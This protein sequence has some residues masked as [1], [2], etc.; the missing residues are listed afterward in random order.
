M[1][2][3]YLAWPPGH[4]VEMGRPRRQNRRTASLVYQVPALVA[5][6]H[7]SICAFRCIFL[8]PGARRGIGGNFLALGEG[9]G[10]TW[11]KGILSHTGSRRCC[12]QQFPLWERLMDMIDK[13]RTSI[14]KI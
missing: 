4:C 10:R 11:L 2:P 1:T 6:S 8:F 13:G 9:E 3:T 14:H 12:C 5:R 7:P